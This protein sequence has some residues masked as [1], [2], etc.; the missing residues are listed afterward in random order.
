MSE[1][2]DM[3]HSQFVIDWETWGQT[4]RYRDDYLVGR[5]RGILG[6]A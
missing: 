2:P 6:N 5:W 1:N 3:G 4:G